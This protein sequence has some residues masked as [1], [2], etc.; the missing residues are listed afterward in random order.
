MTLARH[1]RAADTGSQRQKPARRDAASAASAE[2]PRLT[3][4][5]G[6]LRESLIALQRLAGNQA[7]TGL[8]VG[9]A[10]TVLRLALY[11]GPPLAPGNYKYGDVILGLDPKSMRKVLTDRAA[12]TGLVAERKWKADFVA[13]MQAAPAGQL[14]K[15]EDPSAKQTVSVE[16]TLASNADRGQ[17]EI[18]ESATAA[19]RQFQQDMLALVGSMLDASDAKLKAEAK[20]YGFPDHDS[21][22]NAKP[23]SA[24]QA[25]VAG[26]LPASEEVRGAIRAAKVLLD[27]KRKLRSVREANA[28][29]GPFLAT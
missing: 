29:L 9:T 3:D 21:I 25:A 10:P 1:D 20:R 18:E 28:K 2:R 11:D 16:P 24:G 22:F 6:D 23:P 8:L 4:A 19:Q 27:G 14:H 15:Y 7:V 13:D 12:S 5:T 26:S 17:R